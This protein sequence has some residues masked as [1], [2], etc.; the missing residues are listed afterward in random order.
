[1]QQTTNGTVSI[2]HV[3][4]DGT[5]WATLYEVNVDTLP[6]VEPTT[7]NFVWTNFDYT[8]A[9]IAGD[10]IAVVV[11]GQTTG[12]VKVLTN[13][14]NNAAGNS[15]DTTRSILNMRNFAGTFSSSTTLD[16]AG[17]IKKGG[18]SFIPIIKFSDTVTR[19]YERCINTS[20]SFYDQPL[21]RV[22]V[23]G[24]RTGT[25]PSPSTITCTLKNNANV[26]KV[27]IGT[28]DA[29]SIS[30]S[31]YQDV[32]FTNNNNDIKVAPGD[33]V[34]IALATCTATNFIELNMT[35]NI[36]AG[37]SIMGTLVSGVITDQAQF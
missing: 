32:V 15:Y 26:D 9:I 35:K 19:I 20:S 18:S 24:K 27:I 25:I 29:N 12:L 8:R 1:M 6:T 17:V 34:S 7:F 23:R 37:N 5:Y 33:Y 30:T 3:K 21:S 28:Y 4:A 22:M 36:D 13:I 14:G 11:S 31:V 10:R 2:R 16:I